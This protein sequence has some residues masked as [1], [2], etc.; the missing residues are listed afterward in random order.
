MPQDSELSLSESHAEKV[1]S[2]QPKD[3]EAPL[4]QDEQYV[5]DR[6]D[7]SVDRVNTL[8]K[9]NQKR[10][11]QLKRVALIIGATIPV[12]IT[13]TGLESIDEVRWL[14][15][16][17]LLYSAIGGTVLALMKNILSSGNYYDKWKTYRGL[18]ERLLSEKYLYLTK[19][20]P[21]NQEDAFPRVVEKVESLLAEEE[22]QEQEAEQNTEAN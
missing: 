12:C 6:I 1:H 8:S 2:Y 15:T 16:F 22:D 10:Y 20:P 3:R 13:V 5:R 4:M 14:K 18:S 9:I 11:K 17:L 7:K 19:M 21:Y